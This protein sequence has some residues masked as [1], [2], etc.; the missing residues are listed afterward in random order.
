MLA[1][2]GG[3]G[4][5]KSRLLDEVADRWRLEGGTA[6]VARPIEHD[7]A[8]PWST[9]AELFRR[10]L[11]AAPGLPASPPDALATLAAIAPGLPA[12]LHPQ[13]PRDVQEAGTALRAVIA[14]AVDE[15]PV[16]L[17]IDD[18]EVADAPSLAALEVALRDLSTAP[19]LTGVALAA[20]W[21]AGPEL[22]RLVGRIGRGAPG[23]IV[24]LTP[25]E[26]EDTRAIVD[27]LAGWCREPIQRARLARR[28]H[29]E[30][31][32]NPLLLTTLLHGLREVQSVREDAL[33][34]PPPAAT[35]DAAVPDE[36]PHLAQLVTLGRVRQLD[37]P[38]RAYLA[39]ACLGGRVLDPVVTRSL[40]S[41]DQTEADS[42]L[43]ELEHRGF[44]SF[45]GTHYTFPAPLVAHIVMNALLTPG[46]RH[47]LR[48]RRAALLEGTE[49]GSA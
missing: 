1:L 26:P 3:A 31:G 38:T 40:A 18:A 49:P 37:A 16:A 32:G 8:V 22:G 15:G 21:R 9:I 6:A 11:A 5:G 25:L 24:S 39:A 4:L 13:N 48:A 2:T 35:L 30:T 46:E 45:D 34:W 23:G 10:G 7:Q 42:A 36:V 47:R 17:L 41:L 27:A 12:G 14:A 20:D 33:E 28:L 19:L 43:A 29:F 44:V